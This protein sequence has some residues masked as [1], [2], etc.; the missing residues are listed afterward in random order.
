LLNSGRL[1][2][3][4]AEVG[5]LE[6]L[7]QMIAEHQVTILWLTAGLFHQ[8]VNSHLESLKGVRQLLAGGD[9]LSVQHIL[10]AQKALPHCQIINGY[11]PTENTTFTCCYSVPSN[12]Q[13]GRSTPIGHPITNT[14][15][16]L[17]DPLQQPVP[18]GAPGELYAGGDGV[19]LGYINDPKLTAE[20]FI[21]N[22][23][24]PRHGS[25]L[26]RTGDIARHLPDGTIEFLGR[27]DQQVKV[28]GFRVELEE[29]ETALRACEEVRDCAVVAIPDASGSNF[30]AA[31]VVCESSPVP[32]ATLRAFLEGQL[33]SYMVPSRFAFVSSLPVTVNG[34]LDRSALKAMP[35]EAAPVQLGRALSPTEEKLLRI[36]Q[37]ILQTDQIQAEDNFFELGGHSLLAMRVVSRINDDFGSKLTMRNLFEAPRISALAKQLAVLGKRPD[38]LPIKRRIGRDQLG[39]RVKD[40]S[41]Q[42]LDALL[43]QIT[44]QP[45]K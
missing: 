5:S 22:P 24:D 16:Y 28:R 21:P 17:L 8:M 44:S 27:K 12:W 26:Y 6:Q 7:G 13:G 40:L 1:V 11:G 41:E 35:L 43:K 19:A 2:M 10:R 15:V 32:P 36:W 23:F 45:G 9:V 34:K 18:A 29:I 42:D 31:F 39:V 20:R 30:L 25:R 33:P 37:E 38:E 4:P 3:A 14:Q